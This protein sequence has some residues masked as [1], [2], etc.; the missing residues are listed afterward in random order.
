M[1]SILVQQRVKDF[2]AWKKGYDAMAAVRSSKGAISD[3]VYCDAGDPNKITVM[4][5]WDSLESAK[6]YFQ[7]PELKAAM[8]KAGVEGAPQIH[9]LNEA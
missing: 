9:F 6:S 8:E 2:G 5:N 4:M 1:A 3:Q 7:S